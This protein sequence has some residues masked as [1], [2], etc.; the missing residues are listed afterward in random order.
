ME[1]HLKYIEVTTQLAKCKMTGKICDGNPDNAWVCPRKEPKHEYVPPIKYT[2]HHEQ[3]AFPNFAS[4]YPQFSCAKQ[5]FNFA[6]RCACPW[7]TCN[8]MVW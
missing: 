3:S 6:N 4:L 8:G 5:P 1:C 2:Y 7:R